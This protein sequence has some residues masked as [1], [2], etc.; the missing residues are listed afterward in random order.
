MRALLTIEK[1]YEM[2]VVAI[3]GSPRKGGNTSM[4]IEKVFEPLAAAGIDTECIQLGG[5]AV[6]GC[7]ACYKCFE[8]TDGRCVI[9]NDP[10]NDCIAKMVEADGILLGS[11]TYFAN[12]S[13]EIKALIDRAGLV[14]I[15]NGGLL[16]RKAGAAVVAVRRGGAIHVFNSINQFFLIN[17][18]FVVGSRYWNLAIGREKGDVLDDEEGIDTMVKL[19]ENMAWLLERT[20]GD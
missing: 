12:V 8:N 9:D 1:G 15:A 4:L 20:A 14:A 18:M 17:H 5:K 3:N 7:T 10:V 2:K 13:T 16:R 19:G 11:P 6:H